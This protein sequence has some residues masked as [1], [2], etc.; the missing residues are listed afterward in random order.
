MLSASTVGRRAR[1]LDELQEQIARRLAR[2]GPP[3]GARAYLQALRVVPSGATGG[4]TG[5]S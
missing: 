1:Q 4:A 2:P 3:E 5:G